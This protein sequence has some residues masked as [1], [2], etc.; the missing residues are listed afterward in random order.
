MRIYPCGKATAVHMS[1]DVF[2]S[3]TAVLRAGLM[4]YI[5]NVPQIQERASD[6]RT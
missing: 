3:I 4:T 6:P 1:L 5:R 2:N